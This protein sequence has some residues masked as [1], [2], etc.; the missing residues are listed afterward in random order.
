MLLSPDAYF[1]LLGALGGAEKRI[2]ALHPADDRDLLYHREPVSPCYVRQI[3]LKI[4]ARSRF[5]AGVIL[6]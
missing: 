6:S 4:A 5:E 2:G 3:F 1:A